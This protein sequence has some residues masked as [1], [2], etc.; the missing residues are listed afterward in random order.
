MAKTPNKKFKFNSQFPVS[1]TGVSPCNYYYKSDHRD[2][3]SKKSQW[4]IKP[5]KE[6]SVFVN[7]RT[8]KWEEF[9]YSWGLNIVSSKAAKLGKN[10]DGDSLNVAIFE[11]GQ[12]NSVWHGYPLDFKRNSKDL[13]PTKIL[14]EWR[15]KNYIKK[16]KISKAQQGK[17]CSL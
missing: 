6:L 14:T 12:E 2:G 15:N 10:H 7:A 17:A 8:N 13:P 4:S 9:N 11:G 3:T 1:I 5:P 16:H